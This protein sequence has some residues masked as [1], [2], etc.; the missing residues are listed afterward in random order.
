[1]AKRKQKVRNIGIDAK[2]P[3]KVCQDPK[4]VW[5]GSLPIRGKVIE[6]RVVST[7]AHKTAIIE[8]DYLHF[9]P[10]Y[11]RYERRHSRIVAYK[12]DCIDVKVG[13]IAKIAECRSLSKTKHFVVVEKVEKK[14]EKKK[15]E[16]KK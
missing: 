2:P 13:D 11:E 6:G 14:V 12:P 3:K 9:I 15:A 1:M 5:H 4:C 8:R 7:R 16:R 10:K